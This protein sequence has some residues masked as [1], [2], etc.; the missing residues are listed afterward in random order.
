METLLLVHHAR[1]ASSAA[2]RGDVERWLDNVPVEALGLG[3]GELFYVPR[4]RM[5]V[6]QKLVVPRGRFWLSLGHTSP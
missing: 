6:P 4:L 2:T 1:V 5:R 3:E